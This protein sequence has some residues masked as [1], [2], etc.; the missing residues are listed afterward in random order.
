MKRHGSPVDPDSFRGKLYFPLVDKVV[1]GAL[2]AVAPQRSL[3][4]PSRARNT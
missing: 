3:S 2:I 1:I 4:A